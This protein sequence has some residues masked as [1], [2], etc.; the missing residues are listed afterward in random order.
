LVAAGARDRL[1]GRGFR[2][3][4][5]RA[6]RALEPS[7]SQHLLATCEAKETSIRVFPESA[8]LRTPFLSLI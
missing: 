3:G 7:S 5:E 2:L 1:S 6:R 4:D 8:S